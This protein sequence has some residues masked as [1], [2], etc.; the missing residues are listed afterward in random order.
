MIV[1]SFLAFK[2]QA[3]QYPEHFR[4]YG[5]LAF[6]NN[7][8]KIGEE[9]YY[10]SDTTFHGSLDLSCYIY[11]SPTDSLL[12]YGKKNFKVS[13][14]KGTERIRLDYKERN[15]NC[16]YNSEY[17]ELL[18][19]THATP[20]GSYK[21]YIS[22]KNG[23]EVFNTLILSEVDSNLG[24]NSFIRKDVN[25]SLLP[26]QRSILGINVTKV[27]PGY[28][29]A[30]NV[31][32]AASNK[33]NKAFKAK[34]LTPLPG[35]K[36]DKSFIDFYFHDWY[37]GRYEVEKNISI[38]KQIGQQESSIKNNLPS[39]AN[40][41]LN[42]HQSLFSQFKTLKKDKKD[43]DEVKGTI[44]VSTNGGNGQEPNS[45]IDNNYYELRSMVELPIYGIPV[46]I[47]GFYTSQDHNRQA[48]ASY[49]HFHY[50]VDKAKEGLTKLINGYN[51]KYQQTVSKGQGMQQ[52]YQT[53]VRN[54]ENQNGQLTGELQKELHVGGLGNGNLNL[55]SL[56]KEATSAAIANA[57]KEQAGLK[58]D[59]PIDSTSKEAIAKEQHIRDSVEN[60]YKQAQD[61][62]KILL[63]L[64]QKITKYQTLLTQN[65]NVN[66]FD[67][68]L[69]YDKMKGLNDPGQ[70][71]YKQ[72][73]KKADNLLPEGNVKKFATGLTSFDAGMFPKYESQYTMS[74]QMMK[75]LDMGYDFGFCQAG[76]TLGKTQ[77][78]GRDGSVDNYS[79][80]S[81][82]IIYQPA[83]AQ[84][85]TLIYYGYTPSQNMLKD[86]FFKDIPVAAPSFKNPVSIISAKYDGAISKYVIVGSEF[87]RSM[88]SADRTGAV[89]ANDKTAYTFNVEGNIPTTNISLF[90]NY[91][92][93]GNGFEN[94]SLPISPAGTEQYKLGGRGD[95]FRSFLTLGLEYDYLAQT[96]FAMTGG[97]K[98][99]GFDIKTNSKR[100]PSVAFS[101]KPFSTFRSFTDT[102]SIPQRPIL[103]AVW[104]GRASYQIKKHNQSLR[105]MILYNKSTS[106]MDTVKY[107]SDLLQFTTMYT[108]K[109]WMASL[110]TGYMQ[111]SG[112][113]VT[114]TTNPMGKTTF[115]NVNGSYL[116]SKALSINVGQD[117]GI[118]V[119][120]FCKY[121]CTA[122]CM[123]RFIK[124]PLTARLNLRY[125]N[126]ELN[127][128]DGWKQLYMGSIDLTW[129]FKAKMHN[130]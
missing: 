25:K 101:Y 123:Y 17:V 120:G 106:S 14:K 12:L 2:G 47:D 85:L 102:L 115:V 43:E 53:F 62:Y 58:N 48:K 24:P 111:L 104:T 90:G 73:A 86:S 1:F 4:I 105:F 87:A 7:E 27:V 70:M 16:F 44:S 36:G 3:Q 116:L 37:V 124:M 54:L 129:R 19:H 125:M 117:I 122:G 113:D 39:F 66:Y 68:A 82:R 98:K 71:T 41:D 59:S 112:S 130:N 18:K 96:S 8:N 15:N 38:S 10:S 108:D 74:G 45:G 94:N 107:G 23:D 20:P 60:K 75:G 13:F 80:Y 128:V 77:Y 79:T 126:Y 114:T 56:K 91:S 31:I 57:R 32:D 21:I 35:K 63:A 6:L 81:G 61:K 51:D 46:Q 83:K 119:F 5:D 76:I 109:K 65:K 127:E 84:K 95:F 22:I 64:E 99:W 93:A 121:G 100:Y 26:K 55:D 92:K 103:G 118:A 50:D 72:M 110:N 88:N 42:N 28:A 89:N 52:V 67:S 40:N 29:K 9:A 69:A 33:L 78:I 30:G 49:I 11:N 97:N 34:G